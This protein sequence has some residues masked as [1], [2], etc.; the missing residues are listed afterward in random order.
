MK[1]HRI[2]LAALVLAIAGASAAHAQ[3]TAEELYQAGLYQEE[4]Q[5]NLERAIDVYRQ[6]LEDFSDNRTV[7]AKALL[8]IG[9]CYE[10]LGLREAQQA[11]QGVISNYPEAAQ[12][13]AVARQRLA[14]EPR[15]RKLRIASNPDNGVLSP[16]GSKLAFVSDGS[17]WVVPVQGNVAPD[18]AG[19]PV[20]ITEPTEWIAFNAGEQADQIYVVPAAGGEPQKVPGD[21]FRGGH[22]HNFRLSLAPDGRTLAFVYQDP[23]DEADC[24]SGSISTYSLEEGAATRLVPACASQPAFSPDGEYVAYIK[25]I[26]VDDPESGNLHKQ[27]WVMPAAGGTHVLLIDSVR[28]RSPVWSPDGTKIA[29]LRALQASDFSREVWI[30]RFAPEEGW[31]AGLPRTSW[32]ST[33]SAPNTMPFTRCP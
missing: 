15:F 24:A 9:L 2:S 13:V 17:V 30:V 5:G 16:D 4:V 32:G 25:T 12:E 14:S 3:Q 20:R 18:M 19:E 28:V 8:H 31:Q 33:W 7:G 29:V 6:I 1:A 21:H 23:E 11:Y 27:L 10:K 22:A 26:A